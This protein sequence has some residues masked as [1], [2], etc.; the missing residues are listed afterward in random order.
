SM[1]RLTHLEC[2]RCHEQ[3]PAD[4]PQTV[5]PK[6]GGVLYARY[7]LA[8]IKRTFS[9]ARLAGRAPTMWRYDAVLPEA[10]PVSLGEGFTPMLAS[11]ELQNIFIKDEGLN[12]TGSLKARGLSAAVPMARHFELKKLAIPSAGNAAGALAAYAAAA[13]LEAHIFM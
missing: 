1:S 6:D 9:P 11:R 10:D 7:D 4:R 5:C 13:G 3:Y 12:P 2:T 8:T